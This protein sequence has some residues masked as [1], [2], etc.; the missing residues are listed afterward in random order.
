MEVVCKTKQLL[1]KPKNS[2]F[3]SQKIKTVNKLT[4]IPAK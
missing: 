1:I 3:Y 2:E 4:I